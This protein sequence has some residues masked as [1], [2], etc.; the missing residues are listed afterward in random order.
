MRKIIFK[1]LR[2]EVASYFLSKQKTDTCELLTR[3]YLSFL[4]KYIL[5]VFNQLHVYLLTDIATAQYISLCNLY[6]VTDT[7]T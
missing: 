7:T 6:L 1:L 5:S 3:K 4:G 2:H